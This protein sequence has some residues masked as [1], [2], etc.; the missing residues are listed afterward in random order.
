M[1]ALSPPR[2]DTRIS[3]G[4][5][6]RDLRLP[7][8]IALTIVLA[9]LFW[10]GSR[11]PALNEKALMGGDTPLS[12]LSFDIAIEV[13]PGAS[14]AST[15]WANTVNWI[16]TNLKGMTFGVL[17]GAMALTLLSLLQKRSFKNGFANSALGAMIG[18]PLG[19]C[20]NCAVPIAL[21]L[22]AGRLR[23]ETTLSAMIASP[24]LNVIV[25]TM[26]FALLPVHVAALK[27]F[28]SLM[29]VLVG[30][31]LLCRFIL[32]SETEATRDARAT[33]AVNQKVG[34]LSGWLIRKLTPPEYERGEYGP[35][36]AVKW[37]ALTYGR[38]FLF[39]FIVTVP[40]ML[41]AAVLGALFVEFFSPTALAQ[42]LPLGSWPMLIFG[43]ILLATIMSFAPAPISLD[44][45]LT[46][47]VLSL[48]MRE[49]YGAAMVISLGS[50][51]VYA[52]LVIWRAISLR[53][54]V[55]LWAMVVAASVCAGILAVKL[56]APVYQYQMDQYRAVLAN[57]PPAQWPEA[58]DTETA[59]P[60]DQLRPRLE[61][62][63]IAPQ[64]VDFAHS[65]ES[66]AGVEQ[67][68]MSPASAA[69][70][71]GPVFERVVGKQIGIGLTEP[72]HS[73]SRSF[74]HK[75]EGGVA[76]G[77]IHGDGWTDVVL[78]KS[79]LSGGVA[80]YANVGGRFVRQQI[81]LG[82]LE[83]AAVHAVALADLDGDRS[84]DLV[85]TTEGAGNHILWNRDGEI[86][87]SR[88][89]KL[90][91]DDRAITQSLAFADFDGDG[92]LDI[93]LGN[94]GAGISSPGFGRYQ[95]SV[96]ENAV[97]FNR[98]SG[99]FER[100]TFGQFEGQTLTLLASDVDRNGTIDLVAGDDVADT[101]QTILFGKAGTFQSMAGRGRV[102]PYGMRTSMSYDVGDYNNDLIPDY[103]GGQIARDQ[104]TRNTGERIVNLTALCDQ[105]SADSGWGLSRR[106]SCV[107][108]LNAIS[109][110]RGAYQGGLQSNCL[111]IFDPTYR[112]QC[113]A[114]AL[115]RLYDRR[116]SDGPDL[117][118][119]AKCRQELARNPRLVQICDTLAL[120]LERKP[121]NAR[122]EELLGP[123]DHDSN[124]LFTGDPDG[125]FTQDS[126][127]QGIDRPG[128]TWD[129]RFTDLDQD[130]WQDLYVLTGYWAQAPERDTNKLF[131]NREGRF[132]NASEAFGLDDP[133]PSLSAARLDF[134]RD[135]AIDLVRSLSGPNII[136]HRNARPA[137]RALWVHLRQPN[138]NS[139]AVG[140]RVT[141]CTG[142]TTKIRKGACQMR[143]VKAS[144]GYQSFDPI[145][146]HF[147]LGKA[148]NVSLIVVDW[149]D[150]TR[151]SIRPTGLSHGEIAITRAAA[152]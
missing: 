54:A 3:G 133:L 128:W 2:L 149:P 34:G 66:I 52:F 69:A 21:G 124:L 138:G 80:V 10:T 151:S 58:S 4:R 118:L 77:D 32:R 79:F 126:V 15:L 44:V 57:E 103:Y 7:L 139:M 45:I 86:D 62:F 5:W 111:E 22:H 87:H 150:G 115:T 60:L 142:G 26:S 127:G 70:G 68:A 82:P 50:F 38:N 141:I 113:A 12:G 72:L 98:G 83:N 29:M 101:D 105:M 109:Q 37:F 119:R 48:G 144:G 63:A 146:A 88:S 40:L 108:Q 24:T 49:A 117:P 23:L 14:L 81:D 51:S 17:F 73:L 104:L 147:G 152:S 42:V 8:V 116:R 46:A 145:A 1:N 137:G 71:D 106:D 135:G 92:T 11:Y 134:D 16:V 76:A 125:R 35:L 19:V 67:L 28:A 33:A 31:P 55:A 47:V 148:R 36:A 107:A 89:V 64:P 6:Q 102:F 25:V 9:Y 96:Q 13:V 131:H 121:S 136:L 129:A 61:R 120:P 75:F 140:A 85:V 43:L 41:L 143:V 84:L 112:Q 130:G 97:L 110:L 91:G 99:R 39:I 30:V 94:A 122:L 93:A 123:T 65:G 132:V 53:T 90:P 20:V 95:S 59:V 27:L 114:R 56:T 78:R 100:K 18:A 74:F